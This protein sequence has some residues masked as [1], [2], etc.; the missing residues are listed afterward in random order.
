VL[1][2]TADTAE[3]LLGRSSSRATALISKCLTVDTLVSRFVER[4]RT[5]ME[6]CRQQNRDVFAWMTATVEAHLAGQ[7]TPSLLPEA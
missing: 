6:T 5:V 1:V 3:F 7:P 4:M 2:T